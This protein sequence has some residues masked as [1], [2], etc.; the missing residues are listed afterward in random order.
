M[1]LECEL[2]WNTLRQGQQSFQAVSWKKKKK[3]RER[4]ASEN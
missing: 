1:L 3:E 2:T 4:N